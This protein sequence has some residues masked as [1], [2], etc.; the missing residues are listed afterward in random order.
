MAHGGSSSD[1]NGNGLDTLTDRSTVR[2]VGLLNAVP[3]VCLLVYV[4]PA[5]TKW[6]LSLDGA[7]PSLFRAFS[8]HFVHFTPTHL[9]VNVIGFAFVATLGY[10]LAV[11]SG[12]RVAFLSLALVYVFVFPLFLSAFVLVLGWPGTS[13]GASG[14]VMGFVGYLP[15]GL[16][17]FL[18]VRVGVPVTAHHSIWLFLLGLFLATLVALPPAYGLVIGAVTVLTTIVLAWQIVRD[19][20]RDDVEGV[21]AVAFPAGTVELALIGVTTFLWYQFVAFGPDLVTADGILNVYSH[22][23]GLG[24]GYLVAYVGTV[25]GWL[26]GD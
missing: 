22:G 6:D 3:I 13:V 11:A 21:R 14:V 10:A 19:F 25:A 8:T 18:S 4:L 9:L 1:S 5:S 20:G 7:D 16:T 15:I 17:H 24:M 12:K 2:D 26:D 23:L